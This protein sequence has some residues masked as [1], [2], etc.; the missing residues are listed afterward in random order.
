MVFNGSTILYPKKSIL[1]DK[2]ITLPVT[3]SKIVPLLILLG[4]KFS[5][6]GYLLGVIFLN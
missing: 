3:V 1:L 6:L 5:K 4:N 2:A